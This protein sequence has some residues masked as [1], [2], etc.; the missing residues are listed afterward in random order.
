MLLGFEELL[1]MGAPSVLLVAHKGVV[2]TV[3]RELA[4]LEFQGEEPRLGQV[5]K[6]ARPEPGARFERHD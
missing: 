3:A 6:L 5:V 4:G 2:R 1:G